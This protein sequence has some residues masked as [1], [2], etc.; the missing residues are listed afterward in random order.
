MSDWPAHDADSS[1]SSLTSLNFRRIWSNARQTFLPSPS[2][3][4]RSIAHLTVSPSL[5][6]TGHL[7][8]GSSSP[9]LP[10][11]PLPDHS[12]IQN[13][14]ETCDSSPSFVVALLSLSGLVEGCQNSIAT[15]LY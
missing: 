3:S 11:G 1:F 12:G 4:Q 15:N 8:N 2:N 7:V 10:N 5:E 9:T 6:E 14:P 13:L